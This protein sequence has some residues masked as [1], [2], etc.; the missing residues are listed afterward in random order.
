MNDSANDIDE[1]PP[2][3]PDTQTVTRLLDR[4]GEGEKEAFGELLPLVYEELR[5][6]ARRQVRRSR[7]ARMTPTLD[8]TALVHEAYLKLAAAPDP[9]W[10]DRCHFMAVAAMAMRQIMVDYAR[11]R[12][13]RRRGGDV[14]LLSLETRAVA[15]EEE[16]GTLVA[17]E[18][19]LIRLEA[20]SPRLARVVECTFF[21]GMTQEETA[22]ALGVT[23][24][25]VRRDWT[26]ARAWLHRELAGSC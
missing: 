14:Q 21:G 4:L 24:R 5:R 3:E 25:T 8:T 12:K 10:K 22:A 16:A 7:E 17:V 9:R 6:L 11:R 26:K 18:E 1:H 23:E 19:A 2:G 20:L 13:T 15:I